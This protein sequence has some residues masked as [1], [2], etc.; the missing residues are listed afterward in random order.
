MAEDDDRRRAFEAR[1]LELKQKMEA[2]LLTRAHTLR[3]AVQRLLAGDENAR[4]VLKV[5]GHKLRGIAGS[6]GYPQ[7]TE[8]AAELEQRASLSPPPQLSQLATRLAEAA[9]EVGQR[10]ASGAPRGPQ[11]TAAPTPADA[12]ARGP[13]SQPAAQGPKAVSNPAPRPA[14]KAR[15]QAARPQ[16]Q[17]ADGGPLRVL[18]MDDDPMTLKLLRL[19]LVDI[20]GFDAT[21][22]TAGK[23]AVDEMRL[24][25]FDVVVSDAMMPDMNGK[26]FCAAARQLGGYAATV[27]IIILS[28]ATQDELRWQNELSGPVAWLRKPFAPT[29]LVK[30]IAKVVEQFR[31]Q[32]AQ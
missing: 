16:I 17:G 8:L 31:K 27:P 24:R 21:I 32:A 13:A 23:N 30:D 5:E 10:G 14:G 29:A 4:R 12:S 18:A 20:G 1:F 25:T 6:Y 2:G 28:A 22:V 9:E 15:V 3:D 7:L 11:P 26:E 19:T